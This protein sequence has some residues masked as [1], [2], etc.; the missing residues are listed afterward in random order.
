MGRYYSGS[1]EG[2][3][4]FAIQNSDAANRFGGEEYEPN[5]IQ[6][7]FDKE[8]HL[9]GVESEINNI[10]KALGNNRSK[11]DDL[12]NAGT[13]YNDKQLDE[14]GITKEMLSDYADLELGIKIRDCLLENDYCDFDAEL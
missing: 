4:W 3:F 14:I 9:E 10:I 2:K 1:I 6:Y 12:V 11:I 5:Y 7:H 13:G 8:E